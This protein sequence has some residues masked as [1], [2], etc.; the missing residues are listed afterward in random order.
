MYF[1]QCRCQ[2]P[3]VVS[4]SEQ[5]KHFT[6]EQSLCP[7]KLFLYISLQCIDREVGPVYPGKQ[8]GTSLYLG[9]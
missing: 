6:A 3:N 5:P 9:N 8:D 1:I 2:E 4:L 7:R